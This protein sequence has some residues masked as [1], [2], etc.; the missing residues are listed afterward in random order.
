MATEN[1]L[2]QH[3]HHPYR[4][5]HSDNDYHHR[6]HQLIALLNLSVLG[7]SFVFHDKAKRTQQGDLLLCPHHL[8]SRLTWTMEIYPVVDSHQRCNIIIDITNR[9]INQVA[10]SRLLCIVV[11]YFEISLVSVWMESVKEGGRNKTQTSKELLIATLSLI[12]SSNKYIS[13]T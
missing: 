2:G 6:H 1:L 8:I 3:Q 7:F 4:H 11:L 5:H 13:G 9:I 12:Q 10:K